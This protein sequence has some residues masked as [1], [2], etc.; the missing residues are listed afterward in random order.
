V[1]NS[2]IVACRSQQKLKIKVLFIKVYISLVCVVQLYHNAQCKKR[3]IR[4]F[5]SQNYFYC[6]LLP[7]DKDD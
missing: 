7:T 4:M 3:K 1:L 5:L 2:K 6:V